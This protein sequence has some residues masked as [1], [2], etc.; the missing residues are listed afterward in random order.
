MKNTDTD[1][2]RMNIQSQNHI[3]KIVSKILLKY[4]GID[5]TMTII[6]YIPKT[7]DSSIY[8]MNRYI[9]IWYH[10]CHKFLDRIHTPVCYSEKQ[11]ICYL[12]QSATSTD[13]GLRY[14]SDLYYYRHYYRRKIGLCIALR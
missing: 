10:V 1:Q 4:R 13:K 8:R 9:P 3:R 11:N 12:S 2:K 14:S 5:H 6:F 7:N